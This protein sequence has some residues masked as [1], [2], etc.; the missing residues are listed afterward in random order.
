MLRANGKVKSR[1]ASPARRL[2]HG[3]A[4]YNKYTKFVQVQIFAKIC[5]YFHPLHTSRP[6]FGKFR[7]IGTI[8]A[9]TS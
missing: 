7:F 9:G 4:A 2:L 5:L 6:K 3:K 8:I 1:K